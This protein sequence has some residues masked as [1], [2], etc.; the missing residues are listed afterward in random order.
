MVK[1]PADTLT[2]SAEEGEALIARVPRSDLPRSDAETVEWFIRMYFHVVFALQ[3]GTL[4]TKRRGSCLFGKHPSPCPE[5]SLAVGPA[6]GE[7]ASVCAVL[8]AEVKSGV[9]TTEATGGITEAGAV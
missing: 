8:E 5:E 3:E 6:D 1:K 7:E 4:N 9:T 2:L